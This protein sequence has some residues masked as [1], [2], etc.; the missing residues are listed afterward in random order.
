M[1]LKHVNNDNGIASSPPADAGSTLTDHTV[2]DLLESLEA[3]GW[4]ASTTTRRLP[5]FSPGAERIFGRPASDFHADPELWWKAIHPEDRATVAE[6]LDRLSTGQTLR[7]E[8]RILR[9]DGSVVWIEDRAWAR[10]DTDGTPA[11]FEGVIVDITGRK[12]TEETLRKCEQRLAHAQKM[13]RI[14]DWEW[15]METR[16]LSCS[17]EVFTIFGLER[18]PSPVSHRAFLDAIHPDD[19]ETVILRLNTAIETHQPIS[20]DHRVLWPDGAERIVHTEAEVALGADGQPIRLYGTAQ[21]VTGLKRTEKT[22]LRLNRALFM[23]RECHNALLTAEEETE[24]V[25]R[26]CQNVVGIGG[27]RMAWIGYAEHDAA[28]TVRMV[29]Q[30][31]FDMGYAKKLNVAWSDTEHGRGP[32]GTAIRTRKPVVIRNTQTDPQFAPWRD[33]ALARRY[34]SVIGLPLLIDQDAIGALTIY[35][36]VKD[37]FDAEEVN[38]LAELAKDA[39]YGIRSLRARAERSK[40]EAML[41]LRD[42]AIESSSNG[43][44]ITET[45]VESGEPHNRIIYVN[46]AYERI[47]GY[48]RQEVVGLTPTFLRGKEQEQPGLEEIRAALREQREGSAILRNY[49]KDGSTF[50]NELHV[51]PVR[52]DNGEVTHYVGILN[53]ITDRKHYEEQLEYQANHDSLTDLPNR[54]LLQD[55]VH[56]AIAYARRHQCMAAVLFLDLDNFKFIN[57]SLGHEIGDQVLKHVA[58]RLTASI[59]DGDTVAR[60]GGDEF[61]LVLNEVVELEDVKLIMQRIFRSLAQPIR[62]QKYELYVTC[63]IG[64]SL[65]PRDGVD[66]PT[67]LKYADLAMYRAKEHGKNNFQFYTDEMNAR[68]LE[69]LLLETSLRRALERSEFQLVYQPQADLKTGR[70]IGLEALLRWQH[71]ELGTVS[72][73]RFIPVAEE[74]GLIVPIGEWVLRTACTQ[75]RRWLDAGLPAVP[76]GIN[77]SARQFRQ[78]DLGTFIAQ[79][80][81][82]T[83]ILAEYVELEITEG[84]MME[85]TDSAVATLHMLKELGLHLAIDDFGTG[86]SSLSYLKRFPLDRLKIDR[87]FV[88]DII[89]N[90]DDAAIAR[91]IIAMAHSLNLKVIAEGVETEE[92]L[93][94]L[95]AHGC[96]EIQGY[97]FSR[98]LPPEEVEALLRSGKRLETAKAALTE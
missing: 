82:D 80:I 55:R 86:Y 70:V 12:R 45:V 75:I 93:S 10:H 4:S 98:P 48:S 84:T 11:R 91:A 38:L 33:D 95:R 16:H 53:D 29:A 52:G 17:D 58:Q 21:D 51:A 66:V 69:R 54:N 24:F 5:H 74:S 8:Y 46:P 19:R 87:S 63:S 20:I 39:A 9:P 31:G 18:T 78:Q 97:Y 2:A 72:P 60:Q 92:Q 40:A 76:V 14:G 59:R 94:Y 83:D 34:H 57:D 47:T 22:L 44:V 35:S 88:Q 41:R 64:V 1:V 28:K 36:D 3:V 25:S 26:L 27:Y 32:T 77:L 62:I 43:I 7:L 79:T 42:R 30:A 90:T 71:P 37:A 73:A 49:R 67:L 89:T 85:N 23:L 81:R 15:D 61:V 6:R 68:I 96:D 13:A 56:Q 65:Y 50:W